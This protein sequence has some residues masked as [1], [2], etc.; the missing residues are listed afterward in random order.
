MFDS[1]MPQEKTSPIGQRINFSKNLEEVFRDLTIKLDTEVRPRGPDLKD[2]IWM[3]LL[4]GSDLQIDDQ[5]L[6]LGN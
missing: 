2:A 3:P 4:S 5:A 1:V 6:G